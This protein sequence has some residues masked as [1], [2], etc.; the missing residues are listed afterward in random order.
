[1]SN[2]AS[3]PSPRAES[4]TFGPLRIGYDGRVLAPRPWTLMQSTWA[5]ELAPDLPV[6]PIVELWCG[7]GQIGLAAAVMTERSAVLV[8]RDPT[9]CAYARLNASFNGLVERTEI[10]QRELDA[11][12]DANERFSLMLADP[13]R[14]PTAEVASFGADP[15]GA[16]DGGP[17]GTDLIVQ[18]LAVFAQHLVDGGVA[19]LQ[20]R[21]QDQ[22]HMIDGAIER[23]GLRAGEIRSVRSDRAVLSIRVA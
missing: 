16:I 5:A 6:G 22:A 12:F 4:M 13:P 10:R 3:V 20:V 19:L 17:D 9:A 2:D 7:A 18:C 23:A 14:L 15:M 8:D 21:G 11:A 1:M